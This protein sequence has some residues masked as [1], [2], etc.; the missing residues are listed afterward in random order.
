LALQAEEEAMVDRVAI[1]AAGKLS[2]IL[3]QILRGQ[4]EIIKR[5]DEIM[6]RLDDAADLRQEV[7]RLR[8]EL[9]EFKARCAERHCDAALDA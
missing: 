5:Q 4:D 3:M 6:R 7:D 2:T 8:G 9:A 1:A